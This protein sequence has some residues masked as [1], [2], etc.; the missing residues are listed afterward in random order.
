[1][2]WAQTGEKRDSGEMQKRGDG[3]GGGSDITAA[4]WV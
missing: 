1:M 4:S 2:K 3:G